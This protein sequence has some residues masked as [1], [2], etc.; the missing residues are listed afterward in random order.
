MLLG[1]VLLVIVAVAMAF[2][3]HKSPV[4]VCVE[5][6]LILA[7]VSVLALTMGIVFR[8]PFWFYPA[9]GFMYIAFFLGLGIRRHWVAWGRVFV[10]AVA[11]LA[12]SVPFLVF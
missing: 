8:I 1:I 4:N 12:L 7:C 9:F 5:C 10:S 2:V 11:T 3:I 6:V